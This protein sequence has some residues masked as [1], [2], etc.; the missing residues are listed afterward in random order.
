MVQKQRVAQLGRG[1]SAFD[2]FATC[3]TQNVRDYNAVPLLHSVMLILP[4]GPDSAPALDVGATCRVCP[5]AAC[6]A[7]RE[8]SILNDGV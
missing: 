6:P 5:R 8:P 7:R 1:H 3:E 2:C 4:A